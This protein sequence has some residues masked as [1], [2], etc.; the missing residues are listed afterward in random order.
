MQMP[1]D[2]VFSNKLRQERSY[3]HI[4]H[5][6]YALADHDERGCLTKKYVVVELIELAGL[7]RR[8]YV[9]SCDWQHRIN[10]RSGIVT[11]A[12]TDCK[13]LHVN[14]V[15][16]LWPDPD[17]SMDAQPDSYACHDP[18]IIRLGTSLLSAYCEYTQTYGILSESPKSMKCLTCSSKVTSCCHINKCYPFYIPFYVLQHKGCYKRLT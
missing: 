13:C 4:K 10:V 14:E 6:I 9:C 5:G 11:S 8:I 18:L 17:M 12:T 1:K 2:L 15:L 16:K 7:N 3:F